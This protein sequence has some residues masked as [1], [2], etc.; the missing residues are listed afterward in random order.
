MLFRF[1]RVQRAGRQDLEAAAAATAAVMGISGVGAKAIA[2]T[3]AAFGLATS[4]FDASVNS[5]LF[6]IEPSA[7]R[8]VALK[9]RTYYLKAL[10]LD[11]INSRPGMLMPYR[12][13]DAMLPWGN[14]GEHQ[15][16]RERLSLS[17]RARRN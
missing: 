10:D 1:N 14:R 4:L 2:I 3:A 13:S 6:T 12:V 5:V 15:Q 11:K 8:N 16:R 9:G 17:L 7:L